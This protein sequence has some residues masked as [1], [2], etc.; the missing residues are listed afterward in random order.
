M[1]SKRDTTE[2]VRLGLD[3]KLH[4]RFKK[5]YPNGDVYDCEFSDGKPNGRGIYTS[6]ELTY[7][8][9]F[10]KGLFHG[11]AKVKWTNEENQIIKTFLISDDLRVSKTIFFS[12]LF[13]PP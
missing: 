13:F 6:K 2:S 3:G 4:R 11:D 8:G 9:D 1:Y 7:V 5:V 12:S 10:H